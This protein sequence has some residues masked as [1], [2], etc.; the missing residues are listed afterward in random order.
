MKKLFL[1][2]CLVLVF[3]L[4]GCSKSELPA[5]MEQAAVEE[6]GKEIIELINAG[7][8]Q[9]VMEQANEE[10]KAAVTAQELETA[11]AETMNKLGAMTEYVKFVTG[12]ADS[13]EA[14]AQYGVTMITVKYEEGKARFTLS[15]D[16]DMKLAGIYVH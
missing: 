6:K 3:A 10:L 7:N 8:Y 16:M 2:G 1:I 14:G 4:T 12:G 11:L 9:G 15:F 13:K 5:G